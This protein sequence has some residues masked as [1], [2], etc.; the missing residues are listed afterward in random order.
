LGGDLLNEVVVEKVLQP[1]YPLLWKFN[2][3]QQIFYRLLDFFSKDSTELF[4]RG[5][6]EKW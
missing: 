5:I 1:F 4:H 6:Q 2:G 3:H